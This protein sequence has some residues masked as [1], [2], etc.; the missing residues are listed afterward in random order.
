MSEDLQDVVSLQPNTKNEGPDVISEDGVTVKEEALEVNTVNEV[1][2][3]KVFRYVGFKFTLKKDTCEKTHA[4]DQIEKVAGTLE[5]SKENDVKEKS[6]DAENIDTPDELLKNDKTGHPEAAEPS[7]KTENETELDQGTGMEEHNVEVTPDKEEINMVEPSPESEEPMSPIKQF[8]TQGI[9][10]SLR[11]KKKEDEI[12]EDTK[13]EELKFIDQVDD[14]ETSEITEKTDTKCMCLNIPYIMHEQGKDSQPKGS[15]L[16]PE[17]DPQHSVEKEMVQASP[18]KILFRKFSSRRQSKATETVIED[19]DKVTQQLESSLE[20]TEIQTAEEPVDAEPK[21]AVEE[22]LADASPQESKKKSDSTVSWESLICGSSAKKRARKNTAEGETADNE[23]TTESPLESSFE[24]D[25]DHLTS[26]N[27]QDVEGESGSTWKT[28]KKM[29]TPKRKLRTGESSSSEHIP[30]DGEMNKEDSFSMKKLIVGRRKRK[31]DGRQE[32][33]SSDE[34]GKDAETGDEDDE[35]PAIIPLSEYEIIEAESVKE[36]KEEQ[37][38]VTIEHEMPEGNS[39]GLEQDAPHESEPKLEGKVSNN[40]GALIIRVIPEDLEEM[41]DFISKY[42]ELSD[43]PEEGMIEETVEEPVSSSEWTT[44]GDTLAEDIVDLTADAVTAPEPASE[45]FYGDN[46]TE[47]VS[48]LSQLT[49]S[50]RTSGHVTPL[51][52]EYGVQM[53]NVILQEA[54]QSICM[55]QNVQSVTTKD[56]IQENLAVS[57]SPYIMQSTIPEETRVFVAHKKTEATAICTGLIS[58]E[59]ESVEEHLSAP[60]VETIPVVSDTVPIELVYNNLT[61]AAEVASL[62]TDEVYKADIWEVKTEC[63]EVIIKNEEAATE[64][65]LDVEQVIKQLLEP[66]MEV[67]TESQVVQIVDKKEE[68]LTEPVTGIPLGTVEMAVVD[69]MQDEAVF[70]QVI[71]EHTHVQEAE[72]LLHSMLEEQP[73]HH[74]KVTA[75]IEKDSTDIKDKVPIEKVELIHVDEIQVVTK[76]VISNTAETNV[77]SVLEVVSAD[78][79]A[80]IVEDSSQKTEETGEEMN[81]PAEQS[82]GVVA[83][84]VDQSVEIECIPESADESLSREELEEKKLDIESKE[85]SLTEKVSVEEAE[86]VDKVAVYNEMNTDLDN[87]RVEESAVEEADSVNTT[88]KEKLVVKDRQLFTKNESDESENQEVSEMSEQDVAADNVDTAHAITLKYVSEIS[89]AVLE[90]KEITNPGDGSKVILTDLKS[91]MSQNEARELEV[92]KLSR[93]LEHSLETFKNEQTVITTDKEKTGKVLEKDAI[94]ENT[95]EQAEEEEPVVYEVSELP[96]TTEQEEDTSKMPEI[97]VEAIGGDQP[98]V[99][100]AMEVKETSMSELKDNI[101]DVT[102]V[103]STGTTVIDVTVTAVSESVDQIDQKDETTEETRLCESSQLLEKTQA[104]ELQVEKTERKDEMPSAIYLKEEPS[105]V[106]TT[107]AAPIVQVPL[108]TSEMKAA[109]PEVTIPEIQTQEPVELRAAIVEVTEAKVEAPVVEQAKLETAV[110]I[111]LCLGRLVVTSVVSELEVETPVVTSIAETIDIHDSTVKSLNQNTD[112]DTTMLS[113]VVDNQ[114]VKVP[115][116]THVALDLDTPAIT[117]DST[118][119]VVAPAKNTSVENLVVEEPPVDPVV[120]SVEEMENVRVTEDAPTAEVTVT[121]TI[122]S[123]DGQVL[124]PLAVSVTPVKPTEAL[125]ANTS[126]MNPLLEMPDVSPKL[127]TLTVDSAV[128]APAVTSVV[129]TQAVVLVTSAEPSVEVTLGETHVAKTSVVSQVVETPVISIT[130][131]ITT[132]T[133]MAQALVVTPVDKTTA[134]V[135]ETVTEAVDPVEETLFESQQV[136]I[137]TLM[138]TAIATP[139]VETSALDSTM[140]TH[141]A[142]PLVK[143]AGAEPSVV[144]PK[145]ELST[146]SSITVAVAKTADLTPVVQT[147]ALI[148]VIVKE[149]AHP[150]EEVFFESQEVE[151]PT[152]MPTAI[153]TPVEETSPL[154]STTVTHTASPV[155]KPAGAEPSVVSPE[156]ELSTGSSITVA[157]AE[158]ADLTPVV[159]TPALISVIVKEDAHPL[160]EVF[161]ESQEVETPTLM[162]TAIATPVEETSPLDSTTVTHTASPVVKPAGA[163]PSVVSPEEELSTGSSITVAVA[164]TADLTPVVQTP[165]LVSVNIKEDAHPVIPPVLVVEISS[166]ETPSNLAAMADAP[167]IIPEVTTELAISQETVTTPVHSAVV[168]DLM[169]T[170]TGTPAPEALQVTPEVETPAVVPDFVTS[171]IASLVVTLDATACVNETMLQVVDNKTKSESSVDVNPQPMIEKEAMTSALP[172]EFISPEENAKGYLLTSTEPQSEMEDDVWE[173]AVDS[174]GDDQCRMMETDVSPQDPA[175]IQESDDAV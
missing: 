59:I 148:S 5:D 100:K 13:E 95:T 112:N 82:R 29:V 168:D 99:E 159:Q 118:S 152:L 165:A 141:T 173:D 171:A 109:I 10:A 78:D 110:V 161:F 88:E 119:V 111:E 75:D 9:F 31:S 41:A 17:E 24:A 19:G 93:D 138:P 107:E 128:V 114:E 11:K 55:T 153:A 56:E 40:A 16:L 135:S 134:L 2:L 113:T 133:A 137:P 156:E 105:A 46:S 108:L 21:P 50:P 104:M 102:E 158:T 42:Q 33:T 157:V 51:S 68:R 140:V 72:G 45:E 127:E 26:S 63:L 97:S 86:K 37:I 52:A 150:L 143:P 74:I 160:E 44:Q 53:S 120:D 125:V 149:D 54:V 170:S 62:E 151:T 32:Q 84:D 47:M 71:P 49:E 15:K 8:F 61:N 67:A 155:V 12:Q 142:S 167:V 20:L 146:G 154:D 123:C 73:V 28:F 14:A 57:F 116:V 38:E 77:D 65:E 85:A 39:E 34:T 6:T 115:S 30:S 58:Q 101:T 92:D 22:Q 124:E 106:T 169:E 81:I 144:S 83:L 48:A 164:E 79:S 91:V 69:K 136:E 129:Q 96:N 36:V 94:T 4:N 66:L 126:T 7:Q 87:V 35:T 76:D 25:Y 70:D 1:G 89:N 103:E 60:L 18:L 27:E 131:P 80:V 3:K 139:V 122:A 147:P 172:E 117:L 64:T 175:V 23:K 98:V 130:S 174:I 90:H 121:G 166:V 145:E 163:E 43:I 132:V 162:P